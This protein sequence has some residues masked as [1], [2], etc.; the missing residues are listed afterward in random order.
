M[1]KDSRIP[2]TIETKLSLGSDKE[3]RYLGKNNAVLFC[4]VK[5]FS[6]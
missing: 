2:N 3:D 4:S 5:E 6:F 1:S